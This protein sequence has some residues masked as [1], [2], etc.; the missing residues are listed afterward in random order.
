MERLPLIPKRRTF[1]EISLTAIFLALAVATAFIASRAYTPAYAFHMA[2]F[3]LGSVLA[4]V[5]I[6]LRYNARPIAPAQRTYSA[7]SRQ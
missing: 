4:V 1:G 3:S 2:L 7:I 6:Q 5:G